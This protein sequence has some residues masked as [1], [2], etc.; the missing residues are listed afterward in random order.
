MHGTNQQLHNLV[1]YTTALATVQHV[2]ASLGFMGLLLFINSLASIFQTVN[3][4]N[5]RKA[6]LQ[7]DI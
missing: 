6:S 7:A 4:R 3:N 5:C 1:T 2:V